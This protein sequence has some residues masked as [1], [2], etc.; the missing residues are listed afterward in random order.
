MII[1]RQV[2]EINA[3]QTRQ[4]H[5][6]HICTKLSLQHL[7]CEIVIRSQILKELLRNRPHNGLFIEIEFVLHV[8]FAF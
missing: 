8:V 7:P 2:I 3:V 1:S 4:S 5:E 6:I